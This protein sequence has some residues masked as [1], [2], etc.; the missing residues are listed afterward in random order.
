MDYHFIQEKVI[1][2]DIQ[3]CFIGTIDQLANIFTKGL[4]TTMFQTLMTKLHVVK[5]LLSLQGHVNKPDLVQSM[6]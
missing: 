3:V 2:G 5:R 4:S 1:R 6:G